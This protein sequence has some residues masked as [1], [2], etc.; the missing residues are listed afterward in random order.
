MTPMMEFSI[1]G[2]KTAMTIQLH[3]LRDVKEK[4]NRIRRVMNYT[5]ISKMEFLEK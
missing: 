3:M 1:K 2:V 5:E 4:T